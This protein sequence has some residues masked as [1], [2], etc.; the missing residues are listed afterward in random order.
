MFM[1]GTYYENSTSATRRAANPP[2]YF[3]TSTKVDSRGNIIGITYNVG[4]NAAKRVRRLVSKSYG[5]VR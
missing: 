4:R 2:R 5:G 1:N 3:H